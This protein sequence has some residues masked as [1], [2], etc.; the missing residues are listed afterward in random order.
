MEIIKDFFVVLFSDNSIEAIR[1]EWIINE[2]LCYFPDSSKYY[3]Y[4]KK[5]K[6]DM[7]KL[8]LW[9]QY[10]IKILKQ[11][12]TLDSAMSYTKNSS[13]FENSA[14]EEVQRQQKQQ[15]RKH[16]V[17]T[18]L[19]DLQKVVKRLKYDQNIETI[20][21]PLD[22]SSPVDKMNEQQI[23]INQEV[24]D[25]YLSHTEHSCPNI[26]STS[27]TNQQEI[28]QSDL[29]DN[30][31]SSIKQQEV[32]QNSQNI[33][34]F[35]SGINAD[36][37]RY[38]LVEEIALK[39]IIQSLDELK[40]AVKILT[41]AFMSGNLDLSKNML[42]KKVNS[43]EEL[44]LLSE[45]LQKDD[46]KSKMVNLLKLKGGMSGFTDETNSKVAAILYYLFDKSFL[47]KMSWGLKNGV[48]RG[49]Q[50]CL[51]DWPKIT[52]L[53]REVLSKTNGKGEV[54]V[55]EDS[56]LR[57]SIQGVFKNHIHKKS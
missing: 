8:K 52:E 11:F 40:L 54:I 41:D 16:P 18:I 9:A 6:F 45:Q 43:K 32:P 13:G 56:K 1:K 26:F 23:D 22:V 42:T 12:D 29:V 51:I 25:S 53:M 50:I 57:L 21:D 24:I 14:D 20:E 46:Y 4:I 30:N 36:S 2:Q 47:K 5:N 28:P 7:E 55:V 48:P 3:K 27:I 15:A 35:D 10:E 34:C 49:E 17:H 31:L 39:I 33:N 19:P 44:E 37:P 38:V